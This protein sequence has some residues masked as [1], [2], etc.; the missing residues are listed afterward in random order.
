MADD[1][2]NTLGVERDADAD[3]IKKAFRKLA[4]ET[5]PDANPDD[6][7]AEAK[8]REVA[9]AYEVLSDADK[10][11]RYDRG[12]DLGDLSGMFG[13]S[14]D[15]LLR[16]VFGDGGLFGAAS[17]GANRSRGRDVLARTELTLEDAYTG[18]EHTVEF[19]GAVACDDCHGRGA[20]D[21][22]EAATCDE[23]AGQGVRRVAR[24]SVFGQVMSMVECRSCFGSGSIIPEPC[25]TCSGAGTVQGDREV[26][27]Q[28][29]AGVD[30]GT[31]LRMS[32]QGESA[33]RLGGS[34]DLFIEVHL[35]ED[36]R[37]EREGE[38]LIVRLELGIA[39]ATLGAQ[40]DIPL[41]EG[42]D[43]SL[44]VPEGTQHGTLFR[45]AAKGMPR[46]NRRGR[47]DMVIQANVA[48]PTGL[49]SEQKDLLRDY[50]TAAGESVVESR[51]WFRTR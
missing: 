47:G 16:G 48:V 27:V 24:Q 33:G 40:I 1:Y 30:H 12:G 7:E 51:S 11:A 5:H 20:A 14:L 2:Y 21:G 49:N 29:P 23:C 28:I 50:A 32:G 26:T 37:F 18:I 6:P 45:V 41:I 19:R 34:G 17:R 13:A 22:T 38:H 39:E 36:E 31:R 25:L 9:S 46:L 8:F 42:G 15:D 44:T 10:R 4:R 35:A 3:T 43:H